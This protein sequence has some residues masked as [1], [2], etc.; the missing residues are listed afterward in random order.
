[1]G[2]GETEGWGQG[3][4]GREAG[5]RSER[6]EEEGRAWWPQAELGFFC[7]FLASTGLLWSVRKL[8]LT[9]GKT[10][11]NCTY[12]HCVLYIIAHSL[13]SHHYIYNYYTF[14][15]NLYKVRVEPI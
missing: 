5:A 14:I 1:M 11:K 15:C 8:L 10:V 7:R 4:W 3:R 6:R 13:I 2:A 12:Y 9:C